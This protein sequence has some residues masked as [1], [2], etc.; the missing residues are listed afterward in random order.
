MP[1]AV[2]S[3]YREDSM[4]PPDLDGMPCTPGSA[5]C[6]LASGSALVDQPWGAQVHPWNMEQQSFHAAL[7]TPLNDALRVCSRSSTMI[8][9]T[10]SGV[11][12][13]S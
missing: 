6:S 2:S 1:F 10:A 4:V 7:C 5:S 13:C 11:W 9:R 12:L 8:Q 3:A